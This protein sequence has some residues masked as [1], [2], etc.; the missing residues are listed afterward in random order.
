MSETPESMRAISAI[1]LLPALIGYFL[2]FAA[3]G[4]VVLSNSAFA[5]SHVSIAFAVIMA[6]ATIYFGFY[7]FAS[8]RNL[9]WL[10]VIGVVVL[11]CGL[12]EIMIVIDFVRRVSIDFSLDR[13]PGAILVDCSLVFGNCGFGLALVGVSLLHDRLIREN[14]I[15]PRDGDRS[16]ALDPSKSRRIGRSAPWRVV[17]ALV[18]G[19]VILAYPIWAPVAEMASARLEEPHKQAENARRQAEVARDAHRYRETALV[20]MM[21][22]FRQEAVRMFPTASDET[23]LG[24]L[25]IQMKASVTAGARWQGRRRLGVE[26]MARIRAKLDNAPGLVVEVGGVLQDAESLALA[27][28][29]RNTFLENAFVVRDLAEYRLPE[30]APAGVSV[31]SKQEFN[32]VLGEAIA[33]LFSEI[34]QPAIQWIAEDLSGAAGPDLPQPDLK[35]IVGRA[36]EPWR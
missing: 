26:G 25:F 34:G 8:Q 30:G 29:I 28:E 24:L 17:A 31:Y 6:L 3:F 32:T 5:Q 27:T 20:Q 13:S 9:E 7:K 11:S 4:G 36:G 23:A 10:L 35:I 22:L 16:T 1:C 21:G 15:S 19:L 18:Y 2:V 33:Q 12:L 14:G